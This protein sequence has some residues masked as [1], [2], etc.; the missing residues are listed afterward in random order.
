MP[1]SRENSVTLMQKLARDDGFR[2]L[3]ESDPGSALKSAGITPE[4]IGTLEAKC[5]APCALASKDRFEALL[6]D[7]DGEEFRTAMSFAVARMKV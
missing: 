3:F 5:M 6:A 4:E 1:L 7:V 2:K